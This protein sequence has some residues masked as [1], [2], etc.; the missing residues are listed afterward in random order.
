[1]DTSTTGT[2]LHV[3]R[4]AEAKTVNIDYTWIDYKYILIYIEIRK[5]W[6]KK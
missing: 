3:P 6:T 2:H 4:Q 5:I 1:M